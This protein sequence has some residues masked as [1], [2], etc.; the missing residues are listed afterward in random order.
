MTRLLTGGCCCGE[1]SYKVADN[2][3]RFFFCHCEQCRK[4]TGTAHAANLFTSPDAIEWVKGQQH[5]TR[6]N[7]PG[8]ALSRAFCKTCGSALPFESQ[9]SKYLLVPAGSLNEEPS[10]ELDAQIFCEEQTEWHKKG[11]N[12]KKLIGFGRD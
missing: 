11:L 4:L 3:R 7:Y 2:F 6:F 10:K 5:I 1:V 8:R 12:G 9:D